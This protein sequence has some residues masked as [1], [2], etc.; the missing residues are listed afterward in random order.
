MEARKRCSQ[1]KLEWPQPEVCGGHLLAVP[2]SRWEKPAA[3]MGVFGKALR[4]WARRAVEVDMV[5]WL[6]AVNCWGLRR[7]LLLLLYFGR[8]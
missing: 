2:L 7:R 1:V 3:T 4:R 8:R 6:A 5:T